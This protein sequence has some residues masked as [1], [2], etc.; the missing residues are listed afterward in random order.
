MS[1]SSR[2]HSL[3]T[4]K[5]IHLFFDV[6]VI[7]KGIDGLLELALGAFLLFE[8]SGTAPSL[9]HFLATRELGEDPHDFF[10][11]LALHTSDTLS[12]QVISAI[13]VYVLVRG[14]IKIFL[15]TQLLRERFWAFPI[16]I[17]FL[18]ALLCY[19]L[20]QA[21]TASSLLLAIIAFVD[22]I[23]ILLI[24]LEWRSRKKSIVSHA[25]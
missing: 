23:I 24:A 17:T 5:R 12:F 2:I 25:R 13:T 11:T 22:V 14:V 19:Q 10:A 18:T 4:Q 9:L 1:M 7:I 16:A 3:S 21:Y 15:S 20:W 8:P 6:G